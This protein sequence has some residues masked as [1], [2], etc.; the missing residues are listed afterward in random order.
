MNIIKTGN[1]LPGYVLDI[2]VWINLALI[3]PTV[4]EKMLYIRHD[5]DWQMPSHDNSSDDSTWAY[6]AFI[7]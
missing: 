2:Y 7:M 1:K 5:K 6:T 3:R 4:D